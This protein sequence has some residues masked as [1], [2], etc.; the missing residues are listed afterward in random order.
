MTDIT[1]EQFTAYCRQMAKKHGEIAR[2]YNDMADF[3]DTFAKLEP[4]R[5]RRT[6]DMTVPGENGTAVSQQQ[7]IDEV[8]RKTGRVAN[9][10][11]RLNTTEASIEKLLE[12]AGP[13]YVGERGWL[14][15]RAQSNTQE[16]KAE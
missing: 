6:A 11:K 1:P 10:A 8:K 2:R 14:K 5:F 3:N 9:L 15:I 16:H 13:V 4:Q 12:P 7:F